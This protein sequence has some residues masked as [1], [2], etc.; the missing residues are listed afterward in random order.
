MTIRLLL[1]SLLLCSV[2]AAAAPSGPVDAPEPAA[3]P[4]N[5]RQE[6]LDR[7]RDRLMTS[8]FFRGELADMM[9]DAGMAGK[10]TNASEFET[11]SELRSALIEWIAANPAKAAEVYLQL[12]GGG[13]AGANLP[14]EAYEIT[15]HTN[16]AFLAMIKNL[17]EAA[18]DRAVPGEQLELAARRLYEGPQAAAAPAVQLG[19]AAARGG[20]FFDG[21]YADYKL[22]KAGLEKEIAAAGAWLDAVRGP[23]GKGPA[24]LEGDYGAALARY[25]SFVVAA[26]SVKNRPVITA[27]E[28]AALE[29]GRAGLRAG[30]TALALKARAADLAGLDAA[31]AAAGAQPG[32]ARL[33]ADIAALRS[34]LESSAAA[35]ASGALPLAG[36]ARLARAS[37]E[38]FSALYLRYSAYNGLLALKRLAGPAGFSCFY[39]YALFRYLSSFYPGAAYPRAAAELAAAAGPLDAALAA[40]GAGNMEGAVEALGGRL[41]AIKGAAALRARASSFNRSAQFFGWGLLF[42]PA[43]VRVRRGAGGPSLRPVWTLCGIAGGK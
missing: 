2:P 39:D 9:I 18:G 15:W 42:R 26:S 10:F 32:A 8:L 16:P 33:R 27:G 40:A 31:L 38:A 13:A 17:N 1:L 6:E 22:N 28:S 12:K 41:G 25:A 3:R 35:A 24:G 5:A 29:A 7:V 43:E 4:E 23:A 19:G 30:L 21:A 20:G 34:S 37:E 11:H 14:L 36:L